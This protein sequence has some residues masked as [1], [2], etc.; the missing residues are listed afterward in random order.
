[1]ITRDNINSN[2]WLQNNLNEGLNRSTDGTKIYFQLFA[3][4]NLDKY[5]EDSFLDKIREKNLSLYKV[6]EG[7]LRYYRKTPDII[8]MSVKVGDITQEVIYP[9]DLI[10]LTKFEPF[11]IDPELKEK[12]LK[13]KIN[14]HFKPIIEQT[15]ERMYHPDSEFMQQYY[16]KY[17]LKNEEQ[18]SEQFVTSD[19]DSYSDDNL[20]EGG[21]KRTRRR[22]RKSRKSNKKSRKSRKSRKTRKSKKNNRRRRRRTRR[23]NN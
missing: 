9:R 17:D 15:K 2:T 12:R 3:G 16:K 10:S 6:Y 14:Y 22:I 8:V 20:Y 23:R 1:M 11:N 18:D 4:P 19:Y 5:T 7:E 13:E 21:G